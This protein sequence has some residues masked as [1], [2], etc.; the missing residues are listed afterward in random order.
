MSD[1]TR[2]IV[3]VGNRGYDTNHCDGGATSV[4]MISAT[5]DMTENTGGGGQ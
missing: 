3:T 1:D 2:V 5:Q 4:R